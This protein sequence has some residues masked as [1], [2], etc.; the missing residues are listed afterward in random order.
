MTYPI[1]P[2]LTA[3]CDTAAGMVAVSAAWPRWHL[4]ALALLAASKAHLLA[5]LAL[6][7]AAA[8]RPSISRAEWTALR[9]LFNDTGGAAGHWANATGWDVGEYGRMR[10][11]TQ[12]RQT[13]ELELVLYCDRCIT[14]M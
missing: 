3:A 2:L 12:Q 8:A 11:H 10:M 7:V 9:Q 13:V 6:L 4:A 5:V 14:I 1:V